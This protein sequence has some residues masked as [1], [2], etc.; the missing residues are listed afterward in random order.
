[1]TDHE[2]NEAISECARYLAHTPPAQRPKPLVPA[3]KQMF[4]LNASEVCV[5]ISE[6]HLI[7]AR[8]I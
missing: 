6:S 4:N 5:A 8:A 7:R 1:M 3:M 2:H